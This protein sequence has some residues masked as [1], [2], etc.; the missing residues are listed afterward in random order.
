MI[1]EEVSVREF[2]TDDLGTLIKSPPS[3]KALEAPSWINR[4]SKERAEEFLIDRIVD[5]LSQMIQDNVPQLTIENQL[6]V[7][8]ISQRQEYREAIMT[9]KR[10]FTFEL[11]PTK[12]PAFKPYVEF[13][14]KLWGLSIAKLRFEYVAQPEV[15]AKIVTVTLLNNHLSDVS[16]GSLD[17]TVEMSMLVNGQTVKL[18][19]IN[20]TLN[21]Q[22]TLDQTTEERKPVVERAKQPDLPTGAESRFCV[23]CGAPIARDDGFCERCG[24]AKQ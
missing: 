18:G 7:A 21:L 19:S 14:A 23:I 15:A 16:I 2:A 5:N 8:K 24:A 4:I 6:T 22:R 17:V 11:E 10:E 13:A 1:S 3:R 12:L 20:R 9:R